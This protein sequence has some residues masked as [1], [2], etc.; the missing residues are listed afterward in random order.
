MQFSGMQFSGKF[1]KSALPVDG[2][3]AA[4]TACQACA[5]VSGGMDSGAPSSQTVG[6]ASRDNSGRSA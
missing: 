4:V 2:T 3:P 5:M 1:G 6:L